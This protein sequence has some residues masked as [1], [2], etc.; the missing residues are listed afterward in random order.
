MMRYLSTLQYCEMV[1]GNS[2]SGIIEAPSF[3][4]PTVN[5][6]SR[7]EGRVRGKSVIDCGCTRE[8]IIR[9]LHK[10]QEMKKNGVLLNERNPYE[11]VETS[12][13]ILQVIKE[14]LAGGMDVRKQ[15]YDREQSG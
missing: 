5:I 2:S 6:G 15:F 14:H 1:I 7:Q 8:E 4:I 12:S 3:H 10:A 13:R 11:G 9:A